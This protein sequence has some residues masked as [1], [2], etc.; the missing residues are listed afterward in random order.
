MAKE[1]LSN[2][3]DVKEFLPVL[4]EEINPVFQS[5]EP[6]LSEK[7]KQCCIAATD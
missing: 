5:V 3:E 6:E 4:P 7:E 2:N 1:K